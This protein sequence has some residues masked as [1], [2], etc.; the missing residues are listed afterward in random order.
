M[1]YKMMEENE[2]VERRNSKEGSEKNEHA[3]IVQRVSVVSDS[4]AH[5][6]LKLTCPTWK[7]KASLSS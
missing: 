4:T 5:L 3:C 2:G 6:Y 7:I 1:W